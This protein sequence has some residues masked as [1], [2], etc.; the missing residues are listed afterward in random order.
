MGAELYPASFVV[1]VPQII[2]EEAG[3]PDL[4]LELLICTES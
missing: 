2:V 4:V 3:Q 1:E